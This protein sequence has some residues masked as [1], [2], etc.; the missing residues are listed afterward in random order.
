MRAVRC[1]QFGSPSSLKVETVPDPVPGPGEVVVR[2]KAAGVNYPDGLII[3]GKYQVR[4]SLPFTPGGEFAGVVEECGP[5]VTRFGPG[6]AVMGLAAWGAFAE[7]VVVS[8]ELLLAKPPT[9]EFDVGASF[10]VNY[11]TAFHALCER[12][13][14]KSGETVLVLG[15]A[16]GTG[17]ACVE[18]SKALGARVLAAASSPDKLSACRAQGAD[19]LIDY[20]REDLRERL[21]A[22]TAGRGVD[23]VCDTVGSRFTE[24]A[25]RSMAWRGRFLVIGFAGGEI[26][27]VPLNLVLLKGCAIVGV[28]WGDFLRREPDRAETELRELTQLYHAR[29]VRP[30]VRNRFDLDSTAQALE[31]I[32][33][34]KQVGKC[35]VIP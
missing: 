6:Q 24:P 14:L 8:G 10:F 22:L 34:R 13:Q 33:E 29:R 15:A 31:A 3:Q 12:A 30:T 35:V 19:E 32:M 26:P 21:E 7:K 27:K 20:E 1:N 9:M 2:V 16:G 28:Y 11:G 17:G 5:G 25:L 23:V 18:I 4:P